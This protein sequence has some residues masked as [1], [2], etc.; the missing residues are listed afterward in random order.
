M[1]IIGIDHSEVDGRDNW[2]FPSSLPDKFLRLR[3]FPKRGCHFLVMGL[4][5]LPEMLRFLLL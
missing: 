5:F 4:E 1:R 2:Y 3:I